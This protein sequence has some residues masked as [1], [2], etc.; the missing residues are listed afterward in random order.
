MTRYP[1]REKIIFH[2]A[3]FKLIFFVC[4]SNF[5]TINGPL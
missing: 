5:L 3:G 4:R 1:K 2:I